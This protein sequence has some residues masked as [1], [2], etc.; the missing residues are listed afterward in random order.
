MVPRGYAK[1]LVVVESRT[2][3]CPLAGT[4]SDF[5]TSSMNPVKPLTADLL[6]RVT[7]KQNTNHTVEAIRENGE[8]I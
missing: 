4:V 1:R 7:E 8:T 3:K 6:P 2:I 5:Q